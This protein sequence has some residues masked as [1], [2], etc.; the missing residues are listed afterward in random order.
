MAG[1]CN[2]TPTARSACLMWPPTWTPAERGAPTCIRAGPLAFSMPSR[3]TPRTGRAAGC[4]WSGPPRRPGRQT[5]RSSAASWSRS[6]TG[7]LEDITEVLESKNAQRAAPPPH[8]RPA[9]AAV[10]NRC[11]EGHARGTRVNTTEDAV[12]GR[13]LLVP[14]ARA[15]PAAAL[16]AGPSATPPHLHRREWPRRRATPGPLSGPQHGRRPAPSPRAAELAELPL[17]L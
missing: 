12:S 13:R 8:G 9:G 4:G 2:D 10:I 6:P 7:L 11:M 5:L 15:R 16:G 17:G 1:G 14:Q 3:R